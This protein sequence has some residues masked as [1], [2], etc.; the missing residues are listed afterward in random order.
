MSN[1]NAKP[2]LTGRWLKSSLKKMGY[3][4]DG[5]SGVEEAA[6]IQCLSGKVGKV[7]V[8]VRMAIE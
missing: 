8:T 5:F 4:S 3:T 2:V 6:I 1:E 7:C